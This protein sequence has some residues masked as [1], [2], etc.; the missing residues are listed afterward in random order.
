[1]SEAPSST[2][3]SGQNS[4]G[5]LYVPARR[6]IRNP[7]EWE[8]IDPLTRVIIAASAYRVPGYRAERGRMSIAMFHESFEEALYVIPKE[9]IDQCLSFGKQMGLQ[10]FVVDAF[11]KQYT[12]QAILDQAQSIAD[13][14]NVPVIT[15]K[16]MER[17]MEAQKA[18]DPR[19]AELP[20]RAL[21][22]FAIHAFKVDISDR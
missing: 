18:H 14:T 1:M 21:S 8:D 13:I 7:W 4:G 6:P 2:D 17:F 12:E 16:P 22:L 10:R 11:F 5:E 19:A 20:L 15:S 9:E 3:L